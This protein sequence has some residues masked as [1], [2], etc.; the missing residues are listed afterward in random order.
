MKIKKRV[1]DLFKSKTSLSSLAEH[2]N[3]P[4][5]TY[6]YHDQNKN[7]ILLKDKKFD[8]QFVCHSKKERSRASRLFDKEKGTIAWIDRELRPDDI[9]Y[10]IGAN[11]G[12]YTIFAG[13]RL[14]EKGKAIAFEPH[15]PNANSLI[16]NIF[17]NKLEKKIQLITA[18]LTNVESYGKFNYHSMYASASISQYGGNSYEGQT[19][20][21]LFVE[22]KHGCSL[23]LLIMRGLIQ[24]PHLIK[25]DVDGLDFEVLE[26]MRGLLSSPEAPRSI[27]VELGSDSKPKIMKFFQEIGYALKEKHWTQA[28]LDFIAQGN[29]PE[30][31]PHYGIFYH[32]NYI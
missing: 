11:I 1:M 29:D 9:F 14:G 26:G 3:A 5:N 32:P 31:Y 22:I 27:Q 7:F 13:L 4:S 30:D 2:T 20:N 24:P 19:F 18:A 16:E 17:L 21:P 23:D 25:I 10:D 15:I 12:L 28:G 6:D 8:Y